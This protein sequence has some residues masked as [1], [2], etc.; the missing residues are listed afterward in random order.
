MTATLFRDSMW[1]TMKL[2]LIFSTLVQDYPKIQWNHIDH[3]V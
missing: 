1:V 2:P 3:N